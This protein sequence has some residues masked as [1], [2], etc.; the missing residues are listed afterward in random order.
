[1]QIAGAELLSYTPRAEQNTAEMSGVLPFAKFGTTKL[2]SGDIAFEDGMLAVRI[3]PEW[4]FDKVPVLEGPIIHSQVANT[5]KEALVSGIVYFRQGFWIDKLPLG[6]NSENIKTTTGKN[7]TGHV[8]SMN[9]D[10]L[11]MATPGG[12]GE[13]VRYADIAEIHSPR[14][15]AFT[16]PA[17]AN[18]PIS[19]DQAWQV[20]ARAINL[21][22]TTQTTLAQ[23]KNDRLV[24]GDGD[25]GTGKLVLLGTALSLVEIAQFAPDLAVALN[26]N[27]LLR[28]ANLRELQSQGIFP[29]SFGVPGGP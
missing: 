9:A 14:A 18:G 23:F 13:T 24:Q 10:S 19:A 3:I 11:M 29:G 12:Q 25:W 26:R 8:I 22:P 17:L 1:M 5:E 21:S 27:H 2:P 15:F 7:I 6:G 28:V 4:N 20:N 16:V